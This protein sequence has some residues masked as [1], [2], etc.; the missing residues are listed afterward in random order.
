MNKGND[1][2]IFH[3]FLINPKFSIIRHLLLLFL[4]ATIAFQLSSAEYLSGSKAYAIGQFLLFSGI[5]YLNIYVLAPALLL[6]N[7]LLQYVIAVFMAV[8]LVICLIVFL[9]YMTIVAGNKNY[10]PSQ[11]LL[12][13][14][15]NVLS[16][17]ISLGLIVAGSSTI[18]LFKQWITHEQRIGELENITVKS[19]LEQLKNQINPHFLFNMLNNANELCKENPDE[20]AQIIF[21]LNDLLK[22]QLSD[23]SKDKNRAKDNNQNELKN[24]F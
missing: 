7:K 9:Q 21:K 2:G 4:V 3:D 6:K 14:L 8:L 24:H 1:N 16:V 19:E 11:P 13:S 12:L 20:A 18:L 17:V 22:Y 23:S 10:Q 15:I 5:V